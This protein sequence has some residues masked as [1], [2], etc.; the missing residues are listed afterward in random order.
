MEH[1]TTEE[2]TRTVELRDESS[3]NFLKEKDC[4]AG[5]EKDRDPSVFA[6][7][8]EP[9]IHDTMAGFGQGI[10]R[11]DQERHIVWVNFVAAGVVSSRQHT[12]AVEQITQMCHS[13]S[14]NCVAV[15]LFPNRA[16]DLRS[17][18]VKQPGRNERQS[19][20]RRTE[21][22]NSDNEDAD[23]DSKT[24]GQ[25]LFWVLAC[26]EAVTMRMRSKMMMRIQPCRTT[27][28]MP[29]CA[30]TAISFSAL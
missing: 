26:F 10:R 5:V 9:W 28:Q 25:I 12:F 21:Q 4:P 19:R 1:C 11:L 27:L 14:K 15:V 18:P 6:A 24:K 20:H 22:E 23:G 8:A 16:G 2:C 17:S 30:I 29:F 13:H 7:K 3:F